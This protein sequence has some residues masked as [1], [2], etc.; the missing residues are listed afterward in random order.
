MM[1]LAELVGVAMEEVEANHK[2]VKEKEKEAGE[3]AKVVEEVKEA[4]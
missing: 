4:E 3:A 1:P 2:A